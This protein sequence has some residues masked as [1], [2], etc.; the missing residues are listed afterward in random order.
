[1]RLAPA[2][3]HQAARRHSVLGKG[4]AQRQRL[5]TQNHLV[6]QHPPQPLGALEGCDLGGIENDLNPAGKLQHITRLVIDE[7]HAWRAD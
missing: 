5:A 2:S 7:Q 3:R 4:P 1:M 6:G